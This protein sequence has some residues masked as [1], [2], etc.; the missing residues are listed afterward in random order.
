VQGRF[1]GEELVYSELEYRFPIS[2]CTGVLGGVVFVNG[3][4]TSN[5]EPGAQVRVFDYIKAG[6]GFGLR[7]AADKLS[8]TNIAIDVGFGEK[9]MGIYFGAAEVF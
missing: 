2:P 1:R 8:R 7:I 4:T 3:I 6:Y 5:R 9:S